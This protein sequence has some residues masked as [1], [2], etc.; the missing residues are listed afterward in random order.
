M[1]LCKVCHTEPFRDSVC[2]LEDFMQSY[3]RCEKCEKTAGC[4]DCKFH[5][6][7]SAKEMNRLLKNKIED[8]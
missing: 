6:R 7:H 2:D 3:G 8:T 5:H 4:S 1:F